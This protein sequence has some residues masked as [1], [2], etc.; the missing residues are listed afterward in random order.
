MMFIDKLHSSVAL[1]GLAVQWSWEAFTWLLRGRLK[2]SATLEQCAKIGAD[3]IGMTVLLSTVAGAVLA[4]QTANMFRQTGAETYVGGLVS[5]AIVREMAPIFTAMAVGARAG[6][7]IASELGHMQVSN[8]VDALV[9]MRIKPMAFLALPRL[10]ACITML[11]LLCVLGAAVG[12]FA[13]M[14]TAQSV[15]GINSALFIDSA[16][17]TLR[18]YDFQ[19]LLIKGLCFGLLLGMVCVT[20]GL[21]TKGGAREVG[22]SAMR[23]AV[24]IAI[25]VIMFD[26]VLTWWFYIRAGVTVF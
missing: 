4:L 25:L 14:L 8:Q 21:S 7:A 9:M 24:W 22:L 5:L 11:P 1:T 17:L 16:W 12:I 3:S 23:S 20:L 15:A 19:V 26:F 6:T 2:L 13:G 18:V 10:V